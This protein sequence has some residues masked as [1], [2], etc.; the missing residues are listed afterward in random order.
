MII[1]SLLFIV[2]EYDDLSPYQKEL[3]TKKNYK[4]K[5]LITSLENK[6]GLICDYRTLKQAIEQ[7]L[8]LKKIHCAIK[9]EQKAWLKPY[10]EL[11]TKL[12]QQSNSELEK[13]FFKLMNNTVYGKTIENVL[14]KQDINFCC[15]RNKALKYIKKQTLKEKQYLLKILL[16][17]ILINYRLNMIN[18]YM[19]DFVY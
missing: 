5:K 10:I 1:H 4:S 17:F 14:K 15:E 16:Q 9:C 8:I 2:I 6:K 18:L 12:R 3:L 13:D 7:G 19:Q 11:N